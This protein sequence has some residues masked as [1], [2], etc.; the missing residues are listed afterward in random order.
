M[1]GDAGASEVIVLR[2]YGQLA[3]HGDSVVVPFLL[4]DAPVVAWW[5]GT[6]AG[7]A[8]RRTRSARW[9]SA[10][11]PT[12]RHADSP[13]A[14][15]ELLGEAVT[16]PGDTDL[17]WSRITLWRGLLAAAFDQPPYEPVTA[18]P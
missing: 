6:P 15:I 14:R 18:G 2:L 13:C 3:D 1:G 9:R 11:S 16:S 10:G 8:R 5:P 4:P 12:R 7:P 17:A